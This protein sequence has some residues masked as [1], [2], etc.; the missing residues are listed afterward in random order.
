MSARPTLDGLPLDAAPGALGV[1]SGTA[2][3]RHHPAQTGKHDVK[4]GGGDGKP[5]RQ[6]QAP[7]EEQ[8]RHRDGPGQLQ[9]L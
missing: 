7:R 8:L 6:V 1:P 3:I 2:L 9:E 4:A 5:Q